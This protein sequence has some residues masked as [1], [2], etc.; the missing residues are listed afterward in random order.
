MRPSFAID[1]LRTCLKL[2]TMNGLS[3]L[4]FIVAMAS[5]ASSLRCYDCASWNLV[6]NVGI[7]LK[8]LRS[9]SGYDCLT[10]AS[11]YGEVK[12]CDGHQ[13]ACGKVTFTVDGREMNI[14]GCSPFAAPKAGQC[15]ELEANGVK[16][17]ECYCMDKDLCNDAP[18][19][20]KV[21]FPAIL[22]ALAFPLMALALI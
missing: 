4:V 6:E 15:A 9:S 2:F 5:T 14:R 8:T 10:S 19:V 7:E 17:T 18:R 13:V 21:S 22:M 1:L 11:N 12:Q 20:M 3:V 16:Y